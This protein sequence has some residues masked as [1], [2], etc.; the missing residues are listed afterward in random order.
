MPIN[1]KNF[2]TVVLL[3]HFILA[4][5]YLLYT[6]LYS[7]LVGFWEKEE[8]S[9]YVFNLPHLTIYMQHNHNQIL[10]ELF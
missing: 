6:F 10:S 5:F 3:S 7:Y 9:A 4:Y 2:V 1:F 8:L